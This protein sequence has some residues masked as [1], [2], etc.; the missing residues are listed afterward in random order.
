LLLQF[1]AASIVTAV[2]S[3]AAYA[4]SALVFVVATVA[5]ASV[6]STATELFQLL[7]KT[8]STNTVLSDFKLKLFIWVILALKPNNVR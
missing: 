6:T 5:V 4:A 1:S 7:M 2:I 3:V 8:F